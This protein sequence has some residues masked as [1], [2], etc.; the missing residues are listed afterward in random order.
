MLGCF[1]LQD[2]TLCNLWPRNGVICH[3]LP[4]TLQPGVQNLKF[5]GVRAL[6]YSWLQVCPVSHHMFP[7][8]GDCDDVYPSM[9]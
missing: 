2:G 6:V 8:L 7:T 5:I 4:A 1:K 3:M 9:M